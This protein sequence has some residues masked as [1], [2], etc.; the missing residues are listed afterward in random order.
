M[1]KLLAIALS[2]TQRGLG[3]YGGT[4]LPIYNVRIF[5]IVTMNPPYNAYMLIKMKKELRYSSVVEHMPSLHK[6]LDSI[7]STR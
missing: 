1:M 5:R 2:R 6:A 3:G 4:I 7:F